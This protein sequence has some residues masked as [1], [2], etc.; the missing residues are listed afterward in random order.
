MEQHP[1]VSPATAPSSIT[2]VST[3]PVEPEADLRL[4]AAPRMVIVTQF[5]GGVVFLLL[6][7]TNLTGDP[8]G[9]HRVLAVIAALVGGVA[10]GVGGS[11]SVHGTMVR[12]HMAAWHTP[13]GSARPTSR[14][15]HPTP[16]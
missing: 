11:L 9:W 12:R 2:P 10:F 16:R 13:D 7:L 3:G 15:P 1:A 4:W 5:A 8:S 6:A 14:G